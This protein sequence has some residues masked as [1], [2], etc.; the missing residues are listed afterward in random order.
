MGV[1]NFLRERM[2]KIVAIG[3][4]FSL[5]AFVGEEAVRQG[6][7]FFHDDRNQLGEVSGEKVAYDDYSKRLE[8]N[9]A[10]FKQQSGQANLTAQFT[11]YLQENTWNQ[12]VSTII[13]NKEVEKLGLVVSGD[14]AQSM[15]SGNKPDQ[16]I[17]QAFGNPQTGQLDKARLDGFLNSLKSMKADDPTRAQWTSFITQLVTAKE[18]E[19][20]ISMVTNGLYVN[21]LD[22]KDDYESK[23]KLVNF[24]YI[25][26]DYA[27]IPDNK[28]TL[29][30]DDYKG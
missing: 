22:A 11:G 18:A 17:I 1:M 25:T 8:Q 26:L 24:K 29:T 19:K 3:I 12:E 23:N 7:S 6:S 20:Y 21:S 5:L 16:Q 14:E 27:S 2:G 10:Q 15:V 30:D 9:T 13:L 4:G 28:V